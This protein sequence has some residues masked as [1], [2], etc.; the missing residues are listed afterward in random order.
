MQHGGDRGRGEN[1]R[2]E[3]IEAAEEA[4][5]GAQA[6]VYFQP[7]VFLETSVFMFIIVIIIIVIVMVMVMVN[8]SIGDRQGMIMFISRDLERNSQLLCGH[9]HSGIEGI[10]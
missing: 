5:N 7:D 1:A 4:S 3:E 9:G 10:Q 6:D 2:V 8:I